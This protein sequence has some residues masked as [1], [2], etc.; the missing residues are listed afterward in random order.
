LKKQQG[1]QGT[2]Q[3]SQA[4]ESFG[5]IYSDQDYGDRSKLKFCLLAWMNRKE[6]RTR[7]AE[8]D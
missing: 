5:Q 2:E 1:T 7:R 3:G 4:L 8:E 6:G